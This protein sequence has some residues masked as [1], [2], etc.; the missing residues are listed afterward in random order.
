M[1]LHKLLVE[2]WKREYPHMRMLELENNSSQGMAETRM[3]ALH[4]N[5]GEVYWRSSDACITLTL[6]C[7]CTSTAFAP[8]KHGGE[9]GI[10]MRLQVDTFE[11]LSTNDSPS[12]SSLMNGNSKPSSSSVSSSPSSSS[13]SSAIIKNELDMET[14]VSS[15]SGDGLSGSSLKPMRKHL[16]SSFCRIQLFRLKG[17]QRK[18]KTDKAKIDRLN[19]IDLRRRY[20]QSMKFTQMYNAQFD[21]LYSLV[22]MPSACS[23]HDLAAVMSAGGLGA[24]GMN[25]SVS[26]PGSLLG[27]VDPNDPAAQHFIPA[28]AGCSGAYGDFSGADCAQSNSMMND[29]LETSLSATSSLINTSGASM[30]YNSM[31]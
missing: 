1:F 6:R 24:N 27:L 18:L 10:H 12:S 26:A 20:Q 11:I 29:F 14:G 8:H 17:A 19:P 13:P 21:A 4:I 15:S 16:C 25:A 7:N 30:V 2:Q 23:S 22:P 5:V 28:A 9:K 31:G 3:P